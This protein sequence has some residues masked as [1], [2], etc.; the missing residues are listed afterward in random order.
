M[1]VAERTFKLKDVQEHVHDVMSEIDV[2]DWSKTCDHVIKIEREYRQAEGI[3]DEH[4]PVII[5]LDSDNSD[6]SA[7]DDS[8]EE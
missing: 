4:P 5:N 3:I 8:N 1:L 2:S 7:C 6:D